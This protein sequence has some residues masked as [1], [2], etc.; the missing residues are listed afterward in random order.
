MNILSV[1]GAIKTFGKHKVLDDTG[2]N[3]CTGK[4]TAILG[5]N[6]TGKSTLLKMLFGT[7]KAE[8]LYISING[9]N[10]P[11]KNI[12]PHSKIAYLP[13]D[14]FLPKQLKVRD[15]I[16]LYYEGNEQDRLFYADGIQTLSEK[17]VGNLSMGQ[18]RY[19]ELLLVSN[20]NHPFIMLDEPFSMI[21]PLYKD[22]IK[23]FLLELKKD[24][25]IILTDHYYEDVL[26]ISDK[27]LLL[28]EGKLIHIDTT[29][30]L[31]TH[32]YLRAENL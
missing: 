25:G 10:W 26:S 12:I 18:L 19:L 24:K 27:N 1:S 31:I 28:K 4:I 29:E 7:I 22:K 11:A 13:Q 8:S 21:E 5:R 23:E 15:I 30:D 2:F 6:G 17:K 3:C 20:L 14:S 9:K 16:P 32:G